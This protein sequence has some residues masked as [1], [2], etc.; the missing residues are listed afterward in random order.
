MAA[1][2]LTEGTQLTCVE[3]SPDGKK[4]VP[5]HCRIVGST[6][7]VSSPEVAEPGAA[8]YGWSVAPAEPFLYNRAGLPA[9]QFMT[10]N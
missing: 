9:P 4:W 5:A 7:E 1:R 10:S 6:I 2:T 8:R 3:I